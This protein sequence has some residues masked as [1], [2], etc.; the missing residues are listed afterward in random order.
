VPLVV[1]RPSPPSRAG[2]PR[3]VPRPA[4]PR[5]LR[6][7]LA[8]L[9]RLPRIALRPAQRPPLARRQVGRVDLLAPPP[10]LRLVVPPPS[11]RPRFTLKAPV[12]LAPPPA[13]VP[14]ATAVGILGTTGTRVT[15]VPA[16]LTQPGRVDITE[17]HV[18]LAAG[19]W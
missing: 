9:L 4:P 1:L 11:L 17:F 15:M 5:P 7:A 6:L 18:A 16:D 8:P 2:K 19:V 13:A 10:V 12:P 3:E 14:V